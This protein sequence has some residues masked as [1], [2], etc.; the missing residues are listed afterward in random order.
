M[1][2]FVDAVNYSELHRQRLHQPLHHRTHR[3]I[4]AAVRP[5]CGIRRPLPALR[6]RHE[7][8][9]QRH[10]EHHHIEEHHRQ[11]LGVSAAG[12][13]SLSGK[14][15]RPFVE[16]RRCVGQ[17]ERPDANR[18]QHRGERDQHQSTGTPAE[19]NNSSTAGFV[20]GGGMEVKAP[21]DP[22]LARGP[23]HALGL[24]PLRRP[25]GTDLEQAESG[26]VPGRDH[27][28][29]GTR[30]S[31]F[32]CIPPCLWRHSGAIRHRGI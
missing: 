31:L 8:R 5:G 32:R 3:R 28:L 12:Q 22:H 30:D 23:L 17:A 18:P 1:T 4:A 16:R 19:L 13:I 27:V 11:R 2:D 10:H 29:A 7:R 15:V 14:V 20:M 24:G 9:H 6:V 26:R 25:R 21:V